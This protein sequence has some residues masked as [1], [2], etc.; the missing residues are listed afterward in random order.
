MSSRHL[1][2]PELAPLLDIYPKLEVTRESLPAIRRERAA[3]VL[4]TLNDLAPDNIEKMEHWVPGADGAPAV[5]VLMYKP[6]GAGSSLPA[7]LNLHGGGMIAGL[8]EQDEAANRRLAAALGCAVV[9]PDYRLAPET[10]FPGPL[11]DCRATFDWLAQHAAKL[12]LDPSRIVLGGASA[13]AGLAAGLALQLRDRGGV[14]PVFLFL[15]FPMLDDRTGSSVQTSSFAGEFIWTAA[16]NRFGWECY[17]GAEPGSADVSPYAAPARAT[18]LAGLPPTWLACGALDLFLDENLEFTRRLIAEG[19]PAE[20]H[21]YPGAYHAF[22]WVASARV[23]QT[24]GRDAVEA[25]QRA[26]QRAGL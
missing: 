13:G 17:L 8:P 22:Q 23:T 1:V 2:D 26:F 16:Q 18:S 6:L 9:S 10:P 15:I 25:L 4:A 21:V 12:G 7:Y 3:M 24:F 19:V 14:Q 20:L 11:D 5:R